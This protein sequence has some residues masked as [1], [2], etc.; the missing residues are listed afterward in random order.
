MQAFYE[1]VFFETTLFSGYI[2]MYRRPLERL[3]LKLPPVVLRR[4][5]HG[6]IPS[7]I[8][9]LLNRLKRM[10]QDN[11]SHAVFLSLCIF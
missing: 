7:K 11:T 5:L 2:Y 10:F 6:R 8:E 4:M 9:G 1:N 3:W